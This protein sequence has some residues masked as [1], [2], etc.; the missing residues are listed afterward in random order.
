[1]IIHPEILEF[2]LLLTRLVIMLFYLQ[3]VN[4]IQKKFS[5]C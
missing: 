5:I 2:L 3:G 4:K 1:M